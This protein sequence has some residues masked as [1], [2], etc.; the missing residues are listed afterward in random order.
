MSCCY[1]E[2]LRQVAYRPASIRLLVVAL[3]AAILSV[4]IVFSTKEPIEVPR[5]TLNGQLV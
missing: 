5:V 3:A 1:L 2:A 4:A